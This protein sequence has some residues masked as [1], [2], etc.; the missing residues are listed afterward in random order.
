MARLR[1][2]AAA[3]VLARQRER[4][5]FFMGSVRERMVCRH[6]SSRNLPAHVG[7]ETRVLI[8]KTSKTMTAVQDRD[9]FHGANASSGE[10]SA[11]DHLDP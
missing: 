10:T 5:I 2:R 3:S 6:H 4:A 7:T 11:T 1:M 8:N 9:Q